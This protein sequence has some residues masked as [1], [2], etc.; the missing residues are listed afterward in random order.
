MRTD[1]AVFEDHTPLLSKNVFEAMQLAVE[2]RAQNHQ[3]LITLLRQLRDSS[4]ENELAYLQGLQ[5][6]MKRKDSAVRSHRNALRDA[7]TTL[8]RE[9]AGIAHNSTRTAVIDL[10][11]GFIGELQS[12]LKEKFSHFDQHSDE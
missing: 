3:G 11:I 5:N 9:Q 6:Y 1:R 12:Q 8:A 2:E 7:S 4:E 10:V